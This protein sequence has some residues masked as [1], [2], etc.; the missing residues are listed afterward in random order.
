MSYNQHIID[1]KAVDVKR[2][3]PKNESYSD[4]VNKDASFVTNKIFIGGLPIQ[5]T[6]EELSKEFN[7]Y[8]P[9]SET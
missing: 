7:K 8:G 9:I 4:V 1:E 5:L 3:V 6:E 2:A